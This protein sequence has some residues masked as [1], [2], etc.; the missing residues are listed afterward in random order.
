MSV[1]AVERVL[2]GPRWTVEV[3]RAGG[4]VMMY[5]AVTTAALLVGFVGGMVTSRRTS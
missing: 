3:D 1:P 4:V 5:V 2:A